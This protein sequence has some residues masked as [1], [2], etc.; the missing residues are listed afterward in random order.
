MPS[1]VVVYFA[2]ETAGFFDEAGAWPSARGG[3]IAVAT[4]CRGS[5][6]CVGG[7]TGRGAADA[8]VPKAHSGYGVSFE[9]RS[10]KRLIEMRG[11]GCALG[12]LCFSRRASLVVLWLQ[13]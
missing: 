5:G 9:E 6:T 2:E 12:R 11:R 7:V 13:Y 1:H 3:A 4:G 8:A 10:D